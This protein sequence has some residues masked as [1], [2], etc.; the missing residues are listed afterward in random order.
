[1]AKPHLLTRIK[2]DLAL[3]H[4]HLATARLR[5]FLA[6]HPNDLEMRCVLAQIYRDS[7]NLVEAGR[8]WFLSEGVRPEELA[9][10]ERANPSPWLRL[11]LLRFSGDPDM[12]APSA[13]SRLL[14]LLRDADRF[15]PP[16]I[17]KGPAAPEFRQNRAITVPCLFVVV[18]LTIIALLAAIGVYRVLVLI[19][20]Y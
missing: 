12:L 17:W 9:A 2:H 7:G 6:D 20:N 19:I 16:P 14:A 18:A 4:T 3:G 1:V 5:A 10:F 15:G 13:R 11:R 8:W